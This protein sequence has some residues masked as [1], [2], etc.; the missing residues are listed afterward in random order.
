MVTDKTN[1]INAEQEAFDK[2]RPYVDSDEAAWH[3]ART[4]IEAIK[5][6]WNKII[7]ETGT[8]PEGASLINKEK[9]S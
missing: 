3:V 6:A 9:L 7:W 8:T 1:Q 2:F 4:Y 5:E